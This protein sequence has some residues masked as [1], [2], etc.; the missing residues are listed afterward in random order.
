MTQL[1][2]QLPIEW[3]SEAIAAWK[4]AQDARA[5]VVALR[6]RLAD[7]DEAGR[8]RIGAWCD[9]LESWCERHD[10]VMNV[11]RIRGLDPEQDQIGYR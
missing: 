2:E 4:L 3:L 9:W 5:Y 11:R 8:A 1:V 6:A 7:L 10:P